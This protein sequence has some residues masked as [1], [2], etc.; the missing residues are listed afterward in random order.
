MEKSEEKKAV[1]II[2]KTDKTSFGLLIVDPIIFDDESSS[3]SLISAF[4][5]LNRKEFRGKGDV[6]GFD[7]GEWGRVRIGDE[8]VVIQVNGEGCYR[9]WSISR[10]EILQITNDDG[11]NA[12]TNE[13]DACFFDL[14][15]LEVYS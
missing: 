5:I 12:I 9:A 7:G 1:L 3:S 8:E 10:R 15:I 2:C 14:K 11:I 4:N 6:G 13:R